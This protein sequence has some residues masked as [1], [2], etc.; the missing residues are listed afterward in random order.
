MDQELSTAVVVGSTVA[1][2]AMV[3]IADT[4]NTAQYTDKGFVFQEGHSCSVILD[5]ITTNR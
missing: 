1:M 5:D 2:M 4:V 3:G